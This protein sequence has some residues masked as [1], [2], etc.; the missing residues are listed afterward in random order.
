M[1]PHTSQIISTPLILGRPQERGYTHAGDDRGG[2]DAHERA[3]DEPLHCSYNITYAERPAERCP[4]HVWRSKKGCKD[5]QN[6]PQNA[7]ESEPNLRLLGPAVLSDA[8]GYIWRH[9]SMCL[10]SV[11]SMSCETPNLHPEAK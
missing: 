9:K 4:Q 6:T 3:F 7:P 2:R 1:Q 10:K 8:V 11:N 5:A